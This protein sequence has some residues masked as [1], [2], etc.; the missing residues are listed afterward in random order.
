MAE[1]LSGSGERTYFRRV[2]D[3]REFAIQEHGNQL[4]GSEPY[5]HHLERV[6]AFIVAA[7]G[8]EDEE[9]AA[10]LHD[11]HEDRGIALEV[12]AARFGERP[13]KLVWSVSGEGVNRRD[14][15]SSIVDKLSTFPAGVTLKLA[16][17]LT[18]EKNALSERKFK[19]MKM[20]RA[21]RPL[22]APIFKQ[23]NP[24]LYALWRELEIQY[25]K[26]PAA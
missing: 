19:L 12:L 22:Y 24:T 10:W 26:L 3:A 23:G 6:H 21:E 8:D 14:K 2:K 1:P 18:N 4:Y 15:Q 17:R 11:L 13:A 7:G 9:V 25:E 20:Y 5:S 16:D